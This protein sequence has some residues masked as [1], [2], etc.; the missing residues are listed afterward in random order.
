MFV[1]INS[2]NYEVRKLIIEEKHREKQREK[3]KVEIIRNER[4]ASIGLYN[5]IKLKTILRRIYKTHP[6]VVRE[7]ERDRQ[8]T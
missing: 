3:T 2:T 5:I 6:L 7:K 4:V 8:V 1:A